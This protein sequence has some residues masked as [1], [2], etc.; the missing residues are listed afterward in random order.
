MIMKGP[1]RG[2]IIRYLFIFLFI[3]APSA[4]PQNITVVSVTYNSVVLQWLPPP[5]Q[6][7]NGK[8]LQYLVRLYINI[9]ILVISVCL[10]SD[11]ST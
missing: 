2:V 11:W 8:L 6:S 1:F 5:L 7:R 4:S 9:I 3:L 10:I